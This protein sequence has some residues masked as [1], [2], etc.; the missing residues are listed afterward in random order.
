MS[1]LASA[2]EAGTH[3]KLRSRDVR[4]A[5]KNACE[6]NG[7]DL[8]YFSSH[9]LWKG[10]ITQMRCLGASEDDRRDRGNYAPNSQVMNLTYDYG[11]GIG[12]LASNS[13]VGGHKPTVEDVRRLIPPV[14]RVE[15]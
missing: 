1:C 10:A 13:L 4:E 5:L 3:V 12:P 15:R 2:L 9:S 14:R 8:D 7:L 11:A 6:V